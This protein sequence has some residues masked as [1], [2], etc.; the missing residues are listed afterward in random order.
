VDS[1][2]QCSTVE[3]LE[4]IT[5]LKY[6]RTRVLPAPG[7][8]ADD[9]PGRKDSLEDLMDAIAATDELNHS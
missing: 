2:L 5:G 9:V 7:S 8:L 1:E 3:P 4:R 6:A